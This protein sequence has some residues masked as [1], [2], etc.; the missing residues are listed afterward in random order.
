MW[1]S[2]KLDLW[3]THESS[4]TISE[5][6]I[7]W[8]L[9]RAPRI[10]SISIIGHRP[11]SSTDDG[12]TATTPGQQQQQSVT[13]SPS[14]VA[15]N[16]AAALALVGPYLLEL[17]IEWEGDLILSG[18]TSALTS[19]RVAS[20]IAEQLIVRPGLGHLK[21]LHDIRFK[22]LTS[23]LILGNSQRTDVAGHGNV[24][25]DAAMNLQNNPPSSPS[26][27]LKHSFL[28]P[29][30]LSALRMDGCQ[31]RQLPPCVTSL[32]HLTDL[33]LS[34]NALDTNELSALSTMT[35]LQQLTLMGTRMPRIPRSLSQLTNLRVLYLDGV[36][37]VAMP[38][39]TPTHQQV[40][41]ALGALRNLGILSLGSSRLDQF[42]SA[43][44]DMTSLRALY[45]DNNPYLEAIPVGQ[46]LLKLRVLGIDW[47]VLYSSSHVMTH[48]TMLR[49]LCLTS[50]GG[51]EAADASLCEGEV[52]A[53]LLGHPSLKQVLL[54]MVDGNRLPLLIS[55]LNVALSLAAASPRIA[56]QAVKYSGI[57]NEWIEFLNELEMEEGKL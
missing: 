43:L 19:L 57:S 33:V 46:Y 16:M 27:F 7:H 29:P 34:N 26:Q 24:N 49:K 14:I 37:S 52:S 50:M 35:S 32:Q 18:W 17:V 25:N 9:P 10:E 23:P 36:A 38:H 4:T 48:A 53:A 41:D 54:P 51:V 13:S 22:S 5:S 15:A 55:P 31:L 39:D 40:N 2:V 11:V 28:L 21:H 56:V 42:P 30:C 6:F 20:F 1:K 3:I 44:A 8:V 47:K 45:L 12:T